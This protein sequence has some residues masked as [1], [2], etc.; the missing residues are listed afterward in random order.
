MNGMATN[1]DHSVRTSQLFDD[2]SKSGYR[3]AH[4]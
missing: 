4:H 2:Q 1:P 3:N